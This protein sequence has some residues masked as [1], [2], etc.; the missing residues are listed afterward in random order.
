[1][2]LNRLNKILG[3]KKGLERQDI[4]AYL[5]SNNEEEKNRIEQKSLSS[6]FDRDAFEGWEHLQFDL[7]TM[8]KLDNHFLPKKPISWI[9]WSIP[10]VLVTGFLLLYFTVFYESKKSEDRLALSSKAVTTA[11][12]TQRIVLEET[13][14]LLSDAIDAFEETKKSAQISP[15][16]L[17]SQFAEINVQN[18]EIDSVSSLPI[19]K[20]SS[21][22]PKKTLI[23]KRVMAKEIYLSDFK[24]VDYRKYRSNPIVPIQQ[25]ILT[26]TPAHKETNE[27]PEMTSEWKTVEIPY[28]DYL[29]KSIRIFNRE[30]YKK[31]L[32]R[33]E[34]IV[35]KYPDDINGHFYAGLCLFNFG[36]YEKAIAHFIQCR[37][38]PF[39]N[40]D[41]EAQWMMALSYEQAGQEKNAKALFSEIAQSDGYYTQQALEK[42]H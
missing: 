18:K 2:D 40:F 22:S 10:G 33:F 15:E 17:Q 39:S 7:S 9:Y 20:P 4:A 38:N 37:N 29:E 32:A 16:Q 42:M 27:S 14:V 25:L 30:D 12:Q 36:E 31:S 13:D 35:T 41:E 24:L 21:H 11:P 5:N 26:G 34:T 28:M 3:Q 6:D 19:N 23:S 1:M 8:K